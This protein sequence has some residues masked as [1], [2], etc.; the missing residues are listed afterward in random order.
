M[1]W[2]ISLCLLAVILTS[3]Q[4]F[5][6]RNGRHSF[7]ELLAQRLVWPLQAAITS[8]SEWSYD[9]AISLTRSRSIMQENRELK[10]QIDRLEAEKLQL[11]AYF[12]ENKE[13]KEALGFVI[14]G[15]AKGVPA[16]AI[17]QSSSR[18][19]TM[20]TVKSLDGRTIEVGNM[21]RTEKGL[22][23]RIVSAQKTVGEVLLLTHA[24]HA[25]PAVVQRSSDQGMVYSLKSSDYTEPLLRMEKLR[26]EADIRVGDIIV[27]SS[28]SEMYPPNVPIGTVIRVQ[29]APA[30]S[31]TLRAI[32]KPSAQ[33]SNIN[34]VLVV[35]GA[36]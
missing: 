22:L 14:S 28:I 32:I 26:G 20:L 8:A 18:G 3:W 12:L 31:R 6:H 34:Y 23:G 16:R 36:R 33:I 5:A 17:G 29:S 13:L 21:V 15:D 4:H 25:V 7:P 19:G 35:R 9:V 24:D 11:H 27:T 1:R 30:S 10:T 2:L